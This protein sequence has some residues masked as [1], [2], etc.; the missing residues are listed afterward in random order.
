M[1]SWSLENG[2]DDPIWH[3]ATQT[4]GSYR[5][6]SIK[7]SEHKGTKGNYRA[8]AYIVDNSNNRHYI[9]EK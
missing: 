5:E 4:D 6:K 8:D 9:A 1:S 7:A 3:K 2:Q